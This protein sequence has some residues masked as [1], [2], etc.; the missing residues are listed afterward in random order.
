[1]KIQK[2]NVIEHTH[3]TRYHGWDIQYLVIVPFYL[4]IESF[5]IRSCIHISSST[6]I[7]NILAYMQR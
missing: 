4:F 5:F 6:N 7:L 1:M 3:T 2:Y